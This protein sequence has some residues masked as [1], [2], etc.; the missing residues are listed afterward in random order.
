MIPAESKPAGNALP[1]MPN[2]NTGTSRIAACGVACAAILIIAGCQDLF[3][4]GSTSDQGAVMP[5]EP[6]ST[7]RTGV[8]AW[9]EG[10]TT[11]PDPKSRQ[12]INTAV[13]SESDNMIQLVGAAG[14]WV[15]FEYMLRPERGH[16]PSVQLSIDDFTGGGAAIPASSIRMYRHESVKLARLPA[17]FLRSQSSRRSREFPDVLIPLEAGGSIPLESGKTTPIWIEFQIPPGAA[18]GRCVSNIHVREAGGGSLKTAIGLRV[19]GFALPV[20]AALPTPTRVSIRAMLLGNDPSTGGADLLGLLRDESRRAAVVKA[21]TILQAHGLSPFTD[22]LLPPY[23][24]ATDG[25][26][27]IDWGAYDAF[28]GPLIDGSAYADRRPAYIWPLPATSQYPD[29]SRYEGA[30]STRYAAVVRDYLAKAK[31]HFE[32]KGWG[33][34]AVVMF[35][36]PTAGLPQKGDGARVKR[37]GK[38]T[39]VADKSLRFVSSAIPQS[40]GPFGWHDYPH[41]DLSDFVD[42]W[43]PPARFQHPPTLAE[44]RARGKKTW[45]L[46]D[47]PPFSGSMAI[48]APWTHPRSVPWQA[49]LHEHNALYLSGSTQWPEHPSDGAIPR[50]DDPDANWLLYPGEAFGQREPIVSVRLKQLRLGLQDYCYLKALAD[51]GRGATAKVTVSSLIKAAGTDAYG[52]NYQ[53]AQFDRRMD[54]VEAWYAAR[55][56]IEDELADVLGDKSAGGMDIDTNRMA[57]GRMLDSTRA[58]RVTVDS[59]RL[60]RDTRAE[61]ESYL[62]TFAVT[63]RNE[64]P[65]PFAG[66]LKLGLLPIN[67][68][69]M[70]D[71][72][73]VGPIPEMGTARARLVAGMAQFPACDLEGH[74]AQKIVLDTGKGD[75]VEAIGRLSIL[76]MAKAPS[77]IKIDGDLSDWPPSEGNAAGGYTVIAGGTGDRPQARA[78]TLAYFCQNESTLFIAIHADKPANRGSAGGAAATARFGNVVTYEDLMPVGEDLVEILLDPTG[79]AAAPDDLYHIVMKGSGQAIFEQGIEMT[80]P[81]GRAKPWVAEQK[82][83]IEAGEKSWT[84]EIAIPRST[85]GR[86]AGRSKIWGLNVTRLEPLGNEYSNWAAAQRHCYDPASLGNL[87]WP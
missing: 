49:F 64:L 50:S 5:S 38:L 24:E 23:T 73:R 56:L 4:S 84:A 48:E 43:S 25:S 9:A 34:Q 7:P 74:I 22:E 32:S 15:A 51:Q 12:P 1:A 72:T 77:S 57:W 53:D 79:R 61:K 10:P 87:V 40:M 3:R 69:N 17:W 35:D 55:K 19:R 18:A 37:L 39:H 65:S 47:R 29:P 80:P 26:V 62:A 85:F 6:A 70:S 82:F 13:Y 68:R 42:I 8:K 86:G 63:V 78:R 28:C 20:A 11:L 44:Q 54:S 27:V 83:A 76:Y 36:P 71:V 75:T 31:A 46:P 33:A 16:S 45:L 41:E 52:D 21:F 81:I 60:S 14:E 30:E 59:A 58:V 2:Y 66:T 67:W